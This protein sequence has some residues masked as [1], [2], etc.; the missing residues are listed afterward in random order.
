M[1]QSDQIRIYR[2]L[3]GLEQAE[4][5]Q[6]MGAIR[7]AVSKWERG[8]YQPQA[9]EMQKVGI[10]NWIRADSLLE[11]QLFAP[12]LP[13]V[14]VRPQSINHFFSTIRELLPQFIEKERIG[15]GDITVY[16][17]PDGDLIKM[18]THAIAAFGAMKSIPNLLPAGFQPVKAIDMTSQL[19]LNQ[20]LRDKQATQFLLRGVVGDG[21]YHA[22]KLQNIF[23]DGRLSFN[24]TVNVLKVDVKRR[25]EIERIVKSAIVT[26]I[27]KNV[28][29]Q[30]VVSVSTQKST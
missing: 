5:A 18:G 22:P 1:N 21:K 26:S 13:D 8:D 3:H 11:P 27:G 15:K 6:I 17:F 30:V 7:P 28:G 16:S 2:A 23:W 12:L 10:Y 20:T 14:L 9:A 25:K 29:E 19:P 24:L 4:L